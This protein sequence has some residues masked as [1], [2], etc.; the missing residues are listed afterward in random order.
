[1]HA[2]DL[3]LDSSYFDVAHPEGGGFSERFFQETKL[4]PRKLSQRDKADLAASVSR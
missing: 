4:D 1:M 3:S 2:G